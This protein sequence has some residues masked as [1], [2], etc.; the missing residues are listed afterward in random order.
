MYGF[1]IFHLSD[2]I[3]FWI[4]SV[5]VTNKR[6]QP[7]GS[8]C[9]QPPQPSAQHNKP[10]VLLEQ[11]VGLFQIKRLLQRRLCSGLGLI[12]KGPGP[13]FLFFMLRLLPLRQPTVMRERRTSVYRR[14]TRCESGVTS[15][16]ATST[17]TANFVIQIHAFVSEHL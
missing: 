5:V 10:T 2:C 7:S 1:E 14:R 15:I 16:T 8:H 9:L 13:L 4:L 17:T 11:Q 6:R 3:S 12:L